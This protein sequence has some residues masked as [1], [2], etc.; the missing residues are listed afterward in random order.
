MSSFHLPVT[1]INPKKEELATPPIKALVDT[2]S[3]LTWLPGDLLRKADIMPRRKSKF[4]TATDERIEREVGYAI[5]KTEGFETIDEV[6]FAESGDM[7]LLG[8]RTIEG[9]AAMVDNVA[10]RLVARTLLACATSAK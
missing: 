5:V 4:I 7:T 3:E 8:V 6:V 1:A 9:F 10:H 2:G